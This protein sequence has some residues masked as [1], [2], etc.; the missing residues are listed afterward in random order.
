VTYFLYSEELTVCL[1]TGTNTSRKV[2]EVNVVK[3][4]INTRNGSEM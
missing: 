1:H 2:T 3:H 4:R